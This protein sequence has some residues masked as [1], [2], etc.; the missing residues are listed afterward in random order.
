L[1][2]FSRS[3]FYGKLGRYRLQVDFASE[4]FLPDKISAMENKCPLCGHI[5]PLG[6]LV[7]AECG[8]ALPVSEKDIPRKSN[9][10]RTIGL[11]LL[12]FI[13]LVFLLPLGCSLIYKPGDAGS[14]PSGFTVPT[15]T[16]P[17]APPVPDP[18]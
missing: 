15:P 6:T 4:P 2:I 7:C 8:S 5:N 16:V 12:A 18:S 13:V 14:I 3:F 17:P 10:P 9:W 11:S 1:G